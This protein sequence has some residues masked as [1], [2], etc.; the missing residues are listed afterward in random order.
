MNYTDEEIAR[1]AGLE[2]PVPTMIDQYGQQCVSYVDWRNDPGAVATW[3]LPVAMRRGV[4]VVCHGSKSGSTRFTSAGY[5]GYK[6]DGCDTF[7]ECVIEA[8]MAT[9]EDKA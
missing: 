2:Y 4:L 7:T 3:L 1:A 9:R 8:I 5:A 6:A